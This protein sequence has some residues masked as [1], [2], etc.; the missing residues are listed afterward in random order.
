[1]AKYLKLG[2][3]AQTFFD[4]ITGVHV[5]NWQVIK[6]ENHQDLNKPSLKK[7]I[8]TGHL[9]LATEAE[10]EA[11]N[12][13]YRHHKELSVKRAGKVIKTTEVLV[14]NTEAGSEQPNLD[15]PDLEDE[16]D[17]DDFN[18]DEASKSELIDALKEEDSLTDAQKKGLTK[19]TLEQ[20]R[21]LYKQVNAEE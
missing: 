16:D 11:A 8:T 3:K 12:K 4:P 21:E 9:V 5:N 10:F 2:E 1:M 17:A 6:I 15:N 13:K 14:P 20:L 18:I 7:A 19:L